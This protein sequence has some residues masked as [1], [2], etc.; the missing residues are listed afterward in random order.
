[1]NDVIKN[2]WY[3]ED[4]KTPLTPEQIKAQ[5]ERIGFTIPQ[6]LK[7]LYS[8]SNGGRTTFICF[9]TTSGK[10]SVF[11]NGTLLPMEEWESLSEFTAEFDLDDEATLN[12][13]KLSH[14]VIISRHVFE[15]FVV[16]APSKD[17]KDCWVGQLDVT[18]DE[19]E[20]KQV[21]KGSDLSKLTQI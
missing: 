4:P 10:I 5:E 19:P 2:F 6:F 17:G 20:I 14:A 13:A 12:A 11:Q 9:P 7:D 1:M 18:D 3:S 21:C 15:Y 16:L 8:V